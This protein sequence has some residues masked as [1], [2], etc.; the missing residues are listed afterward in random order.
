[1]EQ[2]CNDNEAGRARSLTAHLKMKE[3]SDYWKKIAED[4][5]SDAEFGRSIKNWI[6]VFLIR[7]AVS[8]F[9]GIFLL[10]GISKILSFI[11]S[12]SKSTE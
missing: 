7:G 12:K 10:G 6:T 9:A 5:E 11:P 4:R 8:L 2:I 1:M 3:V